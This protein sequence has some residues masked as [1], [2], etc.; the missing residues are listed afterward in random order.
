MFK[1]PYAF[2]TMGAP[3]FVANKGGVQ[4]R[5]LPEKEEAYTSI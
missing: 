5:G 2:N 3:Y 4:G 1:K